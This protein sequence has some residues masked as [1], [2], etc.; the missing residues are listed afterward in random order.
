MGKKEGKNKTLK[1]TDTNLSEIKTGI[2]E[3]G[4]I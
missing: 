1:K 2:D 3:E 4:Q